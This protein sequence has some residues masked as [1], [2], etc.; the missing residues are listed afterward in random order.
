MKKL[1]LIVTAIM[2]QVTTVNA[3]EKQEQEKAEKKQE[4]VHY[5]KKMTPTGED[6]LDTAPLK[7]SEEI[8]INTSISNVWQVIDDTPGFSKWFPGVKWAKMEVATEKG[9]GAKR[10]AQL[11]SNKYYEEIIAYE[12]EAKW[13]F[14]MLESNSGMLKTITEVIYLEKI[15]AHTTKVIVKGGYETRGVANLM[16]GMVLKKVKKVWAKALS[17]LKEYTENA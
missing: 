8:I 12:K 6:F 15:D 4:K 17:G 13:G 14:T 10:L 5:K 3:Q 1:V 16:K 9:V 7:F 2:V 11:D